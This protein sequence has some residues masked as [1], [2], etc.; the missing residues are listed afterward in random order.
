MVVTALQRKASVQ[1]IGFS[2]SASNW[3]ICI[4]LYT[5]LLTSQI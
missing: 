5:L 4:D 3:R 1:Q 2:I